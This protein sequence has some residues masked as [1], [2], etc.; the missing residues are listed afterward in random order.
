MKR[1]RIERRRLFSI[2]GKEFKQDIKEAF[3]VFD[4]DKDGFIGAEEIGTVVRALGK[5]P[6]QKEVKEITEEAGGIGKKIDLRTFQGFYK[7]K[8]KKPQDLERDM[9]NAFTALDKDASGRI[10]EAELRQILGTLGEALSP[11]E[12]DLLMRD[13]EVSNEGEISYD[14][15]VDMLVS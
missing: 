1:A 15:F 12:V 7:R 3:D 8:M 6:Y 4:S 5:C 2:L 11:E 14:K 10:L 9:R 13:C